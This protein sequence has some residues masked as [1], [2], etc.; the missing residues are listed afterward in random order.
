MIPIVET[1]PK[2]ILPAQTWSASGC[3]AYP[4]GAWVGSEIS[5]GGDRWALTTTYP[6]TDTAS[7]HDPQP[8]ARDD[9]S[10]WFASLVP[11]G[12]YSDN[13]NDHRDPLLIRTNSSPAR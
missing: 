7:A 10:E 13:P 3:C 2:S 4:S 11:K 6:S 9:G 8:A 12:F 5:D 1:F